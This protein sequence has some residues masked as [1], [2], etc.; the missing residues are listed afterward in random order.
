MKLS[1]GITS[2]LVDCEVG[3]FVCFNELKVIDLYKSKN[4]EEKTN[5]FLMTW[6]VWGKCTFCCNE[7]CYVWSFYLDGKRSLYIE[8]VRLYKKEKHQTCV[9]HFYLYGTSL[10]FVV[11]FHSCHQLKPFL[12]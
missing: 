10:L 6:F 12:Q 4:G 7:F 8:N 2:L 1:F 11:L 5:R 9:C 3:G